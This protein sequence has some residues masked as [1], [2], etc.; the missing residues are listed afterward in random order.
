MTAKRIVDF[1]AS[2]LLLLLLFPLML[3]VSIAVAIAMGTPVVFRQKRPGWRG[4]MFDVLKFRTMT[5]YV[6]SDGEPLDDCM[7]TTFVGR[8]LRD[9]GLDELPQLLN[10]LLGDMSLVG[11]RPLL[12]QYVEDCSPEQMRRFEVRPGITGWAQIH[13]RKALDY[14]K[15]FELDVWYVDHQSPFLDFRILLS[16]PAV[17]LRRDGV[18]ETDRAT[19]APASAYS[20]PVTLQHERKCEM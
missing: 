8:L 16:T 11:P 20:L 17:V 9:T 3:V 7:R 15:R 18:A 14:D 12:K 4:E 2:A 10:V 1:A 5:E 19:A 6:G 13:G